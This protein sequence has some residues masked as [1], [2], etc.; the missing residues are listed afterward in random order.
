MDFL[1]LL[2]KLDAD[3]ASLMHIV[4]LVNIG[5]KALL[6]HHKTSDRIKGGEPAFFG[7][8]AD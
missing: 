8:F 1:G 5:K 6:T 3:Q 4:H 7:M 2:N